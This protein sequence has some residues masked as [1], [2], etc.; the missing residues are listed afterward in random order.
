LKPRNDHVLHQVSGSVYDAGRITRGVSMHTRHQF[1]HTPT[2][3]ALDVAVERISRESWTSEQA[4]DGISR[5]LDAMGMDYDQ[6]VEVLGGAVVSE[7]VR[8]Y[9]ESGLTAG[10]AHARLWRNDPELAEVVEGVSTVLLARAET[11]DDA[12]ALIGFL[13]T[14]LLSP[15]RS[16]R[17]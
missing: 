6:R 5:L 15:G 14:E 13:E 1:P 17:G 12:R 8:P 9:W 4:R 11:Q 3:A 16:Q 7:A 2:V 10:E